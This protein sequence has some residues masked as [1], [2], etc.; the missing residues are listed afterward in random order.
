MA[1][2]KEKAKNIALFGG[3][4]A[5]LYFLFNRKQEN[6][7]KEL[8]LRL[9][10]YLDEMKANNNIS[11]ESWETVKDETDLKDFVNKTQNPT[12]SEGKTLL[13]NSLVTPFVLRDSAYISP[14]VYYTQYEHPSIYLPKETFKKEN[15]RIGMYDDWTDHS[16]RLKYISPQKDDAFRSVDYAM[17]EFVGSPNDKGA[18]AERNT[19]NTMAAINGNSRM[20]EFFMETYISQNTP[21]RYLCFDLCFEVPNECS[22]KRF[23]LSKFYAEGVKNGEF[24]FTDDFPTLWYTNKEGG[25]YGVCEPFITG[26]RN[27]PLKKGYN[28][29]SLRIPFPDSYS[30]KLHYLDTWNGRKKVDFINEFACM[31]KFLSDDTTLLTIKFKVQI[32]LENADSMAEFDLEINSVDL[33]GEKALDSP[34]GYLLSPEDFFTKTCM[35]SPITTTRG[36]D[37]IK[38][39]NELTT[40]LKAQQLTNEFEINTIEY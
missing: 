22:I 28:Y 4:A 37:Y 1:E 18:N 5:L 11:F 25:V 16:V 26:L 10:A 34:S 36:K 12:D 40:V 35:S 13:K 39:F 27:R 7:Q 21:Y 3:A 2:K 14:E 19:F 32:E 23:N 29:V 24:F 33:F 9:Q 17:V 38:Q 31:D 6:S 8:E 15:Y 30:Y 20:N